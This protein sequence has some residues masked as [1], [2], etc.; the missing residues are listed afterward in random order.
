MYVCKSDGETDIVTDS[1]LLAE[2]HAM[3]QALTQ[4]PL[5]SDSEDDHPS[6]IPQLL[7]RVG[8]NCAARDSLEKNAS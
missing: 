2:T 8:D 6:E 5:D 7:Q 1:D 3:S 4:P